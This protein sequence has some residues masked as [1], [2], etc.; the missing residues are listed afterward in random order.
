M[1]AVIDPLNIPAAYLLWF[2]DILFLFHLFVLKQSKK[3]SIFAGATFAQTEV[4][5]PT[6]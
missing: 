2:N 1:V 6:E 4:I 5:R 3:R